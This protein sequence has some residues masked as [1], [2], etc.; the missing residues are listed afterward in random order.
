LSI[1][2]QLVFVFSLSTTSTT[3]TT[4]T[5]IFFQSATLY[6]HYLKRLRQIN[7]CTSASLSIRGFY[8]PCGDTP[9]NE[10]PTKFGITLR[11]SDLSQFLTLAAIIDASHPQ[12]VLAAA[13]A[14]IV[15]DEKATVDVQPA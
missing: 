11:I 2:N 15:D 1:K 3:T 5:T 13:V 4:T 10:K 9:H 7:A 12:L 6:F 14:S 8:V